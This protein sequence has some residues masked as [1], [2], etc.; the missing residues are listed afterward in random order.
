MILAGMLGVSPGRHL[1]WTHSQGRE[2]RGSASPT[3]GEARTHHQPQGCEGARPE[4]SANI[5]CSCRRGDPMRGQCPLLAQ[6]G[7][8]DTLNQCP[9]LGVKRTFVPAL[10]MVDPDPTRTS[11]LLCEDHSGLR[12]ANFTTFP[13]FAVSAATKA[14][15]SDGA[16]GNA[17]PPSSIKRV[18]ILGSARLALAS[19]LSRLMI[20]AGVFAGA[21]MPIHWL[22]SK[23]GTIALTVGISGRSSD[24]SVT[25]RARSFLE[26]MKSIS[27]S[28]VPMTPSIC[29]PRASVIA[30]GPPRYATR[31]IFVPVSI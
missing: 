13:H 20:A 22:A 28:T 12:L 24:A 10:R 1:C 27:N 23:P 3:S 30:D 5:V 18:L 17:L 6:S 21:P 11:R 4:N 15:N 19:S 29:P 2:A 7:H 26:R 9:L 16:P 8:P 31:T 14:P 25:A